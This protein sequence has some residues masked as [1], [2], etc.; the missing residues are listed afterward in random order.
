LNDLHNPF[1][2][3]IAGGIEALASELGYQL[4]LGTGRRHP[5]RERTVV[6]SFADYRVDGLILVS[7]GLDEAALAAAAGRI[8]TVVTGRQ[9]DVEAIDTLAIDE[10]LGVRAVIG[11]LAG[12]GHT[13]ILHVT[14]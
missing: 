2:A 3:D 14:G 11:Y 10:S 5:E 6:T 7:P 8:P 13:D 9:L 12:L 1:F 4:L